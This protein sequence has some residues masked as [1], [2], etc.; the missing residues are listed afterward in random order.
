MDGCDGS[1]VRCELPRQVTRDF[2][3][4]NVLFPKSPPN[5]PSGLPRTRPPLFTELPQFPATIPKANWKTTSPLQKNEMRPFTGN[6]AALLRYIKTLRECMSPYRDFGSS[7]LDCP[8]KSETTV[9]SAHS[10]S[11]FVLPTNLFVQDRQSARF[12][13]A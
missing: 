3:A 13:G 5:F 1:S 7:S 8:P 11:P 10:L 12:S 4:D 9:P 2:Y 6:F